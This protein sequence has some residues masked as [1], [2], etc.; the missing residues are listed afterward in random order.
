[1]PSR[2]RRGRPPEPVNPSVL[3]VELESVLMSVNDPRLAVLPCQMPPLPQVTISGDGEPTLCPNF[4]KAVEAIVH[5]RAARRVP[6]FKLVLLTN[7]T[8]LN[9]PEV[10]AGLRLFTR[11][12]EV[13]AKL[14]VGTQ[15]GMDRINR[16]KVP[17][18]R[19]LRGI[20][21]FARRRPVVIQSMFAELNGRPPSEEELFA[22]FCRLTE[23][24]DA[25]AQIS[26][27]QV[28]S[29][30]QPPHGGPCHHLPLRVL[31]EI[32][33][34]VRRVTGLPVEVF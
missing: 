23:L 30:T 19:I 21:D 4:A 9:A 34:K 33:E 14:D 29:A 1:M 12:D 18:T 31:R 28:Y 32:A 26:L 10:R 27:V 20:L 2:S 25:G 22:Y 24:K 13:W 5:L 11:L 16:S 3:A 17:L 15:S 8:R 6:F 7:A